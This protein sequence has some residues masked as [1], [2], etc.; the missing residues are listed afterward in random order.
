[1]IHKFSLRVESPCKP[2]PN[3]NILLTVSDTLGEETEEETK[4][5]GEEGNG[6][7]EKTQIDQ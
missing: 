5:E 7:E 1:M 2:Q 6:K 4:E 3:L